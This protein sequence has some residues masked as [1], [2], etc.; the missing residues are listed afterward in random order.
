MLMHRDAWYLCSLEILV[1]LCCL[2]LMLLLVVPIL[3]VC[4]MQSGAT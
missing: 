2:R 3:G 4:V 1:A